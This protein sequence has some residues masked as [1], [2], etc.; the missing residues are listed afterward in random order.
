MITIYDIAK[1]TGFSPPTVSKALTGTGGLSAATRSLILETAREMGYTPNMTA[2]SLSTNRS[3][4]IGV[5]YEDYYMLKGFKHPLFSDI[6][7][8]FRKVVEEAGYDLL[9][10]SRTLGSRQMTYVDHCDYRNVDGVLIMNPVPGDNEIIRLVNAG[11]P[12]VSANEPIKGICT[13]VTENVAGATEA[14]QHLVDL[15]HRR[16]AYISGPQK[17]TAPAAVERQKGYELCL[18][19]NGIRFDPKLVEEGSFWHVDAGYA[20]TK[21]LLERTRDFS[22]IFASND[23]LA[24]GVKLAL[25]EEGVRIPDDVSII[26]F[27]GDDIGLYM[28]PRL[29][30]MWQNTEE[31]G[32]TAARMLLKRLAGEQIPEI[33]QIPAKL[34][35]RESC[36][37]IG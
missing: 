10:L 8:N 21:R 28:T 34:L 22:A 18:E 5:I 9:F 20:A 7:N 6:L 29:T 12:C 4:L 23:T 14:V 33:I 36:K 27:D 32:L 17:I 3:Q 13:V 2:R 1:K 35:M 26:G 37:K 30:T 11:R 24:C 16:I 31:I 19:R 15:G 25:E